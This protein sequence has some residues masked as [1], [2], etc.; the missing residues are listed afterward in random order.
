MKRFTIFVAT[1]LVAAFLL[2]P[3]AKAQSASLLCKTSLGGSGSALI[4][5]SNLTGKTIPKGQTLFAKKGN[6]TIKFEAT[7]DIRENGS[8]TYRTS[9]AAF[10]DEGDCLGWY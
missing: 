5:L 4:T 3:E 8:V 7:E 2:S 10:Q 1:V 9:G 6:E